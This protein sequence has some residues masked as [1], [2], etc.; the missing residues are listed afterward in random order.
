MVPD[1]D[2]IWCPHS[3]IMWKHVTEHVFCR[4]QS[5]FHI[6]CEI[7]WW[8]RSSKSWIPLKIDFREWGENFIKYW[9]WF[10]DVLPSLYV[11]SV[12]F[13]GIFH[14]STIQFQY[15]LS[16][17]VIDYSQNPTTDRW[18][19]SCRSVVCDIWSIYCWVQRGRVKLQY[20]L[21]FNTEV[22][23]DTHKSHIRNNS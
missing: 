2:H 9:K 15:D 16:V 1:E 10:F 19:S 14:I 13:S 5:I 11:V 22:T 4:I 17:L 23:P 8:F 20:F 18:E 3:L 6:I 21:F 7:K 12:L